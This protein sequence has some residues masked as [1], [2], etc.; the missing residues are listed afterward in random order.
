MNRFRTD[1]DV[2]AVVDS[3][4]ATLDAYLTAGGAARRAILEELHDG[5]LESVQDHLDGGRTPAEAARAAVAEFGEPLEVALAFAPEV[6]ALHARRIAFMLLRSGPLIGLL[7]AVALLK[8]PAADPLLRRHELIGAW[9][10]FPLIGIII[11]TIV[12]LA[13][14][15][16]A[17]TGRFSRHLDDRSAIA[18]TLAASAGIAVVAGDLMMLSAVAV[19]MILDSTSLALVPVIVASTAS[20]TRLMLSGRASGRVLKMRATV[21]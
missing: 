14:S 10:V 20:L 7:W 3:Y 12:T 2:A 16:V 4:M 15:T 6:A 17:L 21:R 18:P 9:Q 8:S 11:V 13:L 5:L 19:Q 1:Q